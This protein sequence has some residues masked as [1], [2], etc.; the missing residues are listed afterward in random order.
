MSIQPTADLTNRK[1]GTPIYDGFHNL[2]IGRY[3]PPSAQGKLA[4]IVVDN[5]ASFFRVARENHGKYRDC[6]YR[7]FHGS[8]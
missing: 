7:G 6:T 1:R 5:T 4:I 8:F 2:E 3:N